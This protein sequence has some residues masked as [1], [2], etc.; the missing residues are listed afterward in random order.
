MTAMD[1]A[2]ESGPVKKGGGK[3]LVLGAILGLLLG[4]AGFYAVWSGMV[5][6]PRDGAGGADD[7]SAAAES[8]S[9]WREVPGT[10]DIAFLPVDPIVVSLTSGQAQH[11]RFAA[12]LEVGSAHVDE[13]AYLMPRVVDAMNSYLRAVDPAEFSAPGAIINLRAQLMR[14]VALVVGEGRVRDILVMEFVLS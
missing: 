12:Q 9:A 5:F 11:L 10:G 2:A 7:A 13:V 6:G 4:G 1:A 3:G 8:A 14:R